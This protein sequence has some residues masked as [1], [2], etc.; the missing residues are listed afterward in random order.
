MA[1]RKLQAH[2]M[3]Y[4]LRRLVVGIV[5]MLGGVFMGFVS[6]AGIHN[7]PDLNALVV[8][9]MMVMSIGMAIVLPIVGLYVIVKAFSTFQLSVGS[10]PEETVRRFLTELLGGD[11]LP[12]NPV[13]AFVCL[14]RGKQQEIGNFRALAGAKKSFKTSLKQKHHTNDIFFEVKSVA[15]SQETRT[16]GSSDAEARADVVLNVAPLNDAGQPR[17]WSPHNLYFELCK[18]ND[19]WRICSM[20]GGPAQFIGDPFNTNL[21]DPFIQSDLKLASGLI[22]GGWLCIALATISLALVKFKVL[23]SGGFLGFGILIALLG[24]ILLANGYPK[25]ARY[26]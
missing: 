13:V 19:L 25:R 17:K 18:E 1:D 3:P 8:L 15:V 9:A 12:G 20:Q 26:Q 21:S 6:W 14:S 11:L 2:L 23:T 22:L 16:H 5:F 10:N 7:P 4:F 24:L